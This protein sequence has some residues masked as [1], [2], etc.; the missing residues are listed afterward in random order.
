MATKEQNKRYFSFK[1]QQGFHY[2]SLFLRSSEKELIR[3][4]LRSPRRDV[5]L[6][7]LSR[8]HM[9]SQEEISRTTINQGDKPSEQQQDLQPAI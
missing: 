6:S 1:K 2:V 4:V 8:A 3:A 7:F 9:K 5:L